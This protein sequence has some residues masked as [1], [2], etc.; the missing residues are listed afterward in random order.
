MTL[1][2]LRKLLLAGL[3]FLTF[4]V[5]RLSAQEKLSLT[6]LNNGQALSQNSVYCIYKDQ[7]GL[8][9]FATQDSLN[10]YDGYK[11]TVYKHRSGDKNALP[12]NFIT[13]LTEDKDGD[14]W[15]GSRIDGLSRFNRTTDRFTSFRHQS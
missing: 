8:L 4:S 1:I 15:I 7:T 9:W 6:S 10:K 2:C 14:L 13:T 12:S 5:A 11:I 3:F